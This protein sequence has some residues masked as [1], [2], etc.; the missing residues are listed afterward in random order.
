[1][2]RS[3]IRKII[4]LHERGYTPHEIAPL[5]PFVTEQAL[6]D[7]IRQYEQSKKEQQ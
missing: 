3:A 5:V 1:M 7:I 2:R 6:T 4:T